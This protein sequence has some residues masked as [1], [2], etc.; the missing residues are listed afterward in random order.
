MNIRKKVCVGLRNSAT[1]LQS[2]YCHK[3][4]CVRI[5]NQG[6]SVG[7]RQYMGVYVSMHH[8]IPWMNLP[9]NLKTSDEQSSETYI[10]CLLRVLVS[11]IPLHVSHNKNPATFAS[12]TSAASFFVPTL[13]L[14]EVSLG[15]SLNL[16]LLTEYASLYP[17]LSTETSLET[18]SSE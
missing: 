14:N 16:E 2:R 10:R 1:K 17:F 12:V 5:R 6:R 7:S 11:R 8:M 4:E 13:H 3:T 9:F 15:L 18:S